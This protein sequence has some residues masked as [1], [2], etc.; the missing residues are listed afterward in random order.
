MI[1]E[2]KMGLDPNSVQYKRDILGMRIA[3]DGV[4]YTIR[5]YNIIDTFNPKDYIKYIVVCD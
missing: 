3:A 1:E 2:A 5:D 4:I